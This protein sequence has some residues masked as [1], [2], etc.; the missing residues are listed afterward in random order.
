M[1]KICDGDNGDEKPDL[2]VVRVAI[3]VMI[4]CQASKEALCPFPS[5]MIPSTQHF[6]PGTQAT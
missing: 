6:F 3:L 4:G 1:L 5:I 2:V